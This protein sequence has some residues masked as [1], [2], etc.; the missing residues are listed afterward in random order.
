VDTIGVL[1]SGGVVATLVGEV[2]ESAS[3]GGERY[4]EGALESIA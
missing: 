3:I 1:A 4:V 2:V